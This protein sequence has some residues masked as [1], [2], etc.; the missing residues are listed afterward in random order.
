MSRMLKSIF[1]IGTIGYFGYRYRYRLLN[2]VIGTGWLRRL[3]VGSFMS[4]PGVKSK[5]MQSMF[6]G[7][8]EW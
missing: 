1:L 8:S 6:G 4:M 3:A 2:V 5:I 7:P